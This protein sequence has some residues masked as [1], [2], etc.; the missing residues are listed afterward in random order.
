MAL[1]ADCRLSFSPGS[2]K[3]EVPNG[4]SRW[5]VKIA[6]AVQIVAHSRIPRSVVGYSSRWCST[7]EAA[8]APLVVEQMRVVLVY[9]RSLKLSLV[10]TSCLRIPMVLVEN[11]VEVAVLAVPLLVVE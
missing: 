10:A 9:Q 7:W 5:R 2:K 11:V 3:R 8:I 4:E 6:L 1:L